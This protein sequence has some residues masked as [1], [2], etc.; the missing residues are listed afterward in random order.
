VAED[1][2]WGSVDL[3][4]RS[5]VLTPEE[6]ADAIGLAPDR[7]WGKGQAR[8]HTGRPHE[9]SGVAFGSGLP[10]NA[11]PQEQ[12]DALIRRLEPY[13]EKIAVLARRVNAESDLRGKPVC[14]HFACTP[15]GGMP[16]YFFAAPVIRFLSEIGASLAVSLYI[17][18]DVVE[19]G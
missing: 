3:V 19:G 4:I 5:S 11:H 16:G 8:N 10:E 12:M 13:G 15:T 7:L 1:D 2:R 6:L 17:T 14:I 18:E 9:A